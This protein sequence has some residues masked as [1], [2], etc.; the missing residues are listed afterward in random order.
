MD[1]YE[2]S[3]RLWASQRLGVPA[4]EITY[5]IFSNYA[6]TGC[7]TCGPEAH[8]EVSVGLRNDNT[9]YFECDPQ[10]AIKGCLQ[11]LASR[12]PSQP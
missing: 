1:I 3:Q 12:C 7:D 2:Q 11:A 5:V 9:R 8:F 10:D 4:D 6:S